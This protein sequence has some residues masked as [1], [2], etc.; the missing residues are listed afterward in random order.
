MRMGRP[1]TFTA[2]VWREGK[3]FIALC[4]EVDVANQGRSE[5]AALKNLS[6]APELHFTP[7]VAALAPV[8]RPVPV[9]ERAA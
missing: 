7:P 4:L 2:S 3:W 8:V 5:A 1:R 9:K 6:D